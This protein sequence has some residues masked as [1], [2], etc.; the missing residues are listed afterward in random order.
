MIFV[1]G[2]FLM[3]IL[4][5]YCNKWLYWQEMQEYSVFNTLCFQQYK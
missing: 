1:V 5:P 4:V 3:L 2:V